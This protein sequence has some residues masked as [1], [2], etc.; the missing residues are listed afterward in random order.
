MESKKGSPKYQVEVTQMG[1]AQV[2]ACIMT[3]HNRRVQL[4]SS[5]PHRIR[6]LNASFPTLSILSV[7]KKLHP[8]SCQ[9]SA[10]MPIEDKTTTA[11]LFNVLESLDNVRL[12]VVARK[13]VIASTE[14]FDLAC[15]LALVETGRLGVLESAWEATA[16][17][18]LD[19][20][21]LAG[22]NDDAS[23]SSLA[24]DDTAVEED[25]NEADKADE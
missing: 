1:H 18:T 24:R 16:E 7:C 12:L 14:A 2:W 6:D 21:D 9:S 8:C 22:W 15:Q 13:I 5:I 10:A 19:K 17:K 4:R 11:L 3:E 20:E 23:D 25:I